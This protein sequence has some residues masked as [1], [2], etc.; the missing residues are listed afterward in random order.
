MFS[1]IALAV[2]ALVA[3]HQCPPKA[4]PPAPPTVSIQPVGKPVNVRPYKPKTP[5]PAERR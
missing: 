1:P 2:A 5:P 4:A 3:G